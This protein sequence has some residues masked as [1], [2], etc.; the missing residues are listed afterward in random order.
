M[1]ARSLPPLNALRAFEAFGRRGRMTLAAD[2]LCVTHGAISRQI[3][4]LEDHLGVAL[5]E[6]P[7]NRLTLT[8]TGLTLAQALTQALDQIEAALPRSAGAGDGTLVVSCLPTFAMKW[9][10]PR[11]PDFVAAHPEIQARIVESNGPFDFRADGVDLAI[12]MRLPHAPPSPDADVTPFLKHYVGP[13]ASPD[14]AAQVDDLDSLARL[15][16]LH[17]RTFLE[18][19]AEW[20]AAAGVALS[21]ATVNREFDHYFYMLEAA[22]AGLGVAL[23][24]YAFVEK[25]LAAGRLVAPLGLVPGQAQVCALTPR[26]KATR[27]ARRFRDWLVVQGAATASPPDTRTGF[28]T[29]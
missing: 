8:E 25:D 3:R 15:P 11:L 22:A 16:R 18:S 20:E 17:T 5:T 4:Q 7:R 1:A 19:W 14:L 21:P 6:G 10:I 13:V 26:G 2:E 24:P 28:S 23:S 29:G 27:A 9:L 12:R